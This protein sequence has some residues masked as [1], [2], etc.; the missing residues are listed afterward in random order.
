MVF[1]DDK[2]WE[3]EVEVEK[4]AEA[5]IDAACEDGLV[6]PDHFHFQLS[7]KDKPMIVVAAAPRTGSTFLSNVLIQV[8]KLQNFRLCSGYSTNEHDLYLPALC[9]MNNSGCVSQMHMKGTFH[10]ASLMN[11]FNIRPII[12]V[13][14]I[15]DIV[16]SLF[17]DLRMKEERSGYHIGKIGFSFLW[18]DS[19]TKNL[20]DDDLI[21][22]IIDLAIPWYVNFYV[23]WYRL[24]EQH[25]VNPIWVNYEDLMN[26]KNNTVISILNF[27]DFPFNGEINSTI[28]NKKHST[29]NKGG[30]G[31]GDI[32]LSDERKRRIMKKFSYYEDV[33]FDR[34]FVR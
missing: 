33:N 2:L 23:S 22:M 5:L 16:A 32:F 6:R 1:K 26:D 17:D 20:N 19:A 8:T 28:L 25:I 31:R 24:T 14:N 30:S 9:M 10:N 13:R 11:R 29:Y 3:L 7:G 12:L 15:F 4:M 27:I 34:Y 18:L 21:D